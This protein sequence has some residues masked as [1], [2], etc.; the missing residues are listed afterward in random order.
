MMADDM[1]KALFILPSVNMTVKNNEGKTFPMLATEEKNL[2]L[3]LAMIEQETFDAGIVDSVD[4]TL[5]MY[6]CG[7]GLAEAI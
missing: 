4:R 5:L 2:P 7:Y 6:V 1:A 3:L